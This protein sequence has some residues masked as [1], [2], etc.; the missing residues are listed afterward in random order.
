MGKPLKNLNIAKTHLEAVALVRMRE[1]HGKKYK[2][3]RNVGVS[4]HLDSDALNFPC[5][6]F[7][8]MVVQN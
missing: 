8:A 4:D 2:N 6:K 5:K 1:R 3:P 7:E